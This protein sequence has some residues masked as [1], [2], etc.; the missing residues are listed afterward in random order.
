MLYVAFILREKAWSCCLQVY[1]QGCQVSENDKSETLES[2]A[3][4]RWPQ[5]LAFFNIYLYLKTDVLTS[6]P[7]SLPALWPPNLS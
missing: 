2:E 6:M 1:K 4:G 7:A 3:F 5:N